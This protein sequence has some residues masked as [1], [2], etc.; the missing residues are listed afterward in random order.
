MPR[1]S[2]DPTG[3][4]FNRLL[5]IR[6]AGKDKNRCSMW[7]CKCDCGGRVVVYGSDLKKGHTQSCGCL[8]RERTGNANR[9]HGGS[10]TALYRAWCTIRQRCEDANQVDYRYYGGRGIT[11]CERWRNFANFEKDM[12]QRPSRKHSIDRIDNDGPYSPENCRWATAK[13]Q[14]ANRRPAAVKLKL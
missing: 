6:S 11:V 2:Y 8:Q 4:R 13:E 5:V 9:T 14:R 3:L 7:Y 10:G 12:G 1:V